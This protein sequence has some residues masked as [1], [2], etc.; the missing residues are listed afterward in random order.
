MRTFK[1]G[2]F[3]VVLLHLQMMGQDQINAHHKATD[4]LVSVGSA[5]QTNEVIATLSPI[6]IEDNWALQM[7]N[8]SPHA[9]YEA[10]SEE[11]FIK[12]KAEA[13]QRRNL[14]I[15]MPRPEEIHKGVS[16]TKPPVLLSNFQGNIID[17]SIPLDNTM[18]ISR[19][20]FVVSSINSNI[21]FTTSDGRIT[22][23]KALSD[24][25]RVL[26]LSGSYFD[27]RLIYDTEQN[28]FVV[29]VLSGSAP[30]NNHVC[31][32]FSKTEDPNGE[33]NFYKIKGDVANEN[34]W[35]DFPNIALS[36]EDLY[37]SGNMFS[38]SNSSAYSVILQIAKAD[39]YRGDDLTWK[40]YD[41]VRN[42]NGNQVF[43]PVP[44][45]AGWS[46]LSAPGLYFI[47]RGGGGN[48]HVHYT[49]AAVKDNAA[50]LS[51][52]VNGSDIPSPPD[53]RQKGTDILLDTGGG[54]IRT[55]IVLD[56]V[57]HFANQTNSNTGDASIF[58][59]RLQ[60]K[61][62]TLSGNILS[63]PGKEYAYPTLTSFG[64]TEK[65]NDILVNYSYAGNN[66]FPGQAVRVVSGEN[67]FFDWS[68]EV[69]L[70]EG[71][72]QIGSGA[73]DNIRWGDY[74]GACRRFGVDR[75]ESW[76][77]GCYGFGRRHHTWIGQ[78]INEADAKRP[79]LDFTASHTTVSKDSTIIFTDLSNT[80]PLERTWI[81]QGANPST[82]TDSMPEVRYDADGIY[83]VTLI[84]T[85]VDGVDTLTKQQY[86]HIQPP[87]AK[88]TANWTLDR[89]TIF[90]G[91]TVRFFSLATGEVNTY[92]WNFIS[93]SPNS[94]TEK[95]PIIKYN[96]E[97]AFLVTHT[98]SNAAGAS[99]VARQKAVTV[100]KKAIPSAAFIADFTNIA[101][102]E[103]VSFT[104]LSSGVPDARNWTFDGGTPTTS[105]AQ[106]PVIKYEE[107]GSY[108]VKLVVKND[109]GTDSTLRVDYIQVGQSSVESSASESEF[110]LFPN[111]ASSSNDVV[112]LHFYNK[113]SGFYHFELIDAQGKRIKN[114][115]Q[116][117]VKIGENRLSF[118]TSHLLPA[119]YHIVISSEGK[120]L[121]TLPLVILRDK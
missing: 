58:Y 111:P 40:Y 7:T 3:F 100:L 74:T 44:V 43:N 95:N 37:I 99:T 71:I 25:F 22:F 60:L 20:G 48:I 93:G 86:I 24:F 46:T 87:L 73:V 61:T 115:Y 109:L 15:T 64:S 96:K 1:L 69:I 88:P 107:E 54:R 41:R 53:A 18:A 106:N 78:Y 81:F 47:S 84:S 62:K 29:V 114:L 59:G 66:F 5:L 31:I 2:V 102:G 85:F 117:K 89:D 51:F 56:S 79:I 119:T 55:A 57:I 105:T 97:G 91:D 17:N 98:T 10:M 90:I 112:Q 108:A 14:P 101:V 67:S 80:I 104:D 77:V 120:K 13:N 8:F 35:F 116:D 76:V 82:S 28:K 49:N 11:E 39:G 70:K 103:S 83:D 38:E 63:T 121:K 4:A 16:A 118:Q 34:L 9:P 42:A 6:S 68:E 21:I 52:S 23:Q 27:P 92:K 30:T 19:N 75:I 94:S 26:G 33:W 50:L 110:K 65:D 113:K 36:K 32:A 12:L 72:S 45:M